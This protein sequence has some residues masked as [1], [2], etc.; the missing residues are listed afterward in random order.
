MLAGPV[1][2]DGNRRFR[3]KTVGAFVDETDRLARALQ[4]GD[5]ARAA[6][7]EPDAPIQLRLALRQ[8]RFVSG[9]LEKLL[10]R[11]GWLER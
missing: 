9:E 7:E 5:L 10:R 11:N 2:A 6:G 3:I 1:T 4:E 8:L